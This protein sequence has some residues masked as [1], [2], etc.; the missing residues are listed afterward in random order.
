M[1]KRIDMRRSTFAWLALVSLLAVPI[2]IGAARPHYGATLRV[3]A[4]APLQSLDPIVLPADAA[5]RV[6]RARVL[7]LV[8]ETLVNIN[9]SGGLQPALATS[10]SGDA[11]GLRWRFRVRSGLKLHDGTPLEPGRVAAILAARERTWKVTADTESIAIDLDRPDIDLPWT[12]A[13]LK[14]AIAITNASSSVIG[15]GSFRVERAE[16]RGLLLRANEDYWAG[17]PFLDAVQID[18]G[19][20]ADDQL[21]DLEVGRADIVSIRA[22]DVRRVSQRGLRIAASR[23][24]TLLALAFEAHRT[25]APDQQ[26]RTAIAHSID[27]ATIGSVLLQRQAEPAFTILPSWLSGYPPFQNPQSRAPSTRA[28]PAVPSAARTLTLRVDPGDAVAQSVAE[29]IAVDAREA[30]LTVNVQIPSGLVPRPDVRLIRLPI[31]PTAPDRALAAAMT[32]LGARV[33]AAATAEPPQPGAPLEAVYRTERALIE[34]DVIVPVV[35]LPE[36]YGLA[37][38]VDCWNGAAITP[39][40]GWNIANVWLKSEKVDTPKKP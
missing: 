6:T 35:H 17:R 40:G 28:M 4:G 39:L 12:L 3:S 2:A 13:D 8:V 21:V 24:L 5:E 26:I 11:R 32:M 22:T 15:T 27:R 25:G 20:T 33:A 18:F 29:R 7:P 14:Y 36:L 1:E 9:A 10:W 16:P 31:D 34:R 37:D 30:G 38:R 23:P 19:R